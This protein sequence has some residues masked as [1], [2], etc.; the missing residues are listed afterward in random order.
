MTASA[1]CGIQ[2]II[3]AVSHLR[4]AVADLDAALAFSNIPD[5][6]AAGSG[7]LRDL[8]RDLEALLA[9]L[10]AQRVQHAEFTQAAEDDDALA[11]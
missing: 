9:Q 1:S 4:E 8:D 5:L 10:G 6:F 2:G 3:S 7:R 11:T